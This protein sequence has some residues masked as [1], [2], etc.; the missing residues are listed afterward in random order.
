[1]TWPT[2]IQHFTPKEFDSPDAPGSG[3]LNMQP[4][5][6]AQLDLLRD[7][8][9]KR[10]DINSGFRT[11]KRNLWLRVARGLK[12]VDSSAHC[13]GWAADIVIP[14][15]NYRMWLIYHALNLGFRRIGLGKRFIHLD[16]DPSKPQDVMW[17]Y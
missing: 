17:T 4:E 9:G 11:K 7:K 14:N 16:A 13:N 2:N 8:M 6:I 12:S 10:M 5:F 15:S 3:L 1:M